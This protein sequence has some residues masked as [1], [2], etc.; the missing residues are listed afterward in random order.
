MTELREIPGVGKETEKDLIALGYTTMAALAH[1]D[2][3]ELYQRECAMK[4]TVVDRC[5]LYVYRCAV[6][7]CNA[8]HPEPEKCKWWYWKDQK[9][10]ETYV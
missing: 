10:E 5:Q 2:P 9:Q 6:Y 8:E 4:G 1:A 3:E 7:Y